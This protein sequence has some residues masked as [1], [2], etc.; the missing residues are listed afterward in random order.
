M[1]AGTP[2]RML[3]TRALVCLALVVALAFA[4]T[5]FA[6]IRHF[7][8]TVEGGGT[9]TFATKFRHGKTRLVR[10]PVRF[11]DVP[12]TC[13]QGNGTLDFTLS[14]GSLRVTRRQFA[15]QTPAGNPRAKITGTFT[16]KGRRAHGTF[17]S[18]GTYGSATGCDTETVDWRAHRV[19]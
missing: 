16:N 13:D 3:M 14:G 7:S 11:S 10:T 6:V 8:G 19:P 12:I 18:Y 2:K 1:S 4:T 17:R 5:A 9:V 15:Y